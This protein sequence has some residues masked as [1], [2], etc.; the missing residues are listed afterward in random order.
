MRKMKNA[1]ATTLAFALICGSLPT[2][3]IVAAATPTISVKTKYLKVGQSSKLSIKNKA[4]KATYTFTSSNTKIATVNKTTGT[5]K[6]IKVG[7]CTVKLTAK[8]GSKTYTSTVKVLV[9]EH[10]SSIRISN[11]TDNMTMDIGSNVFEC[12]SLMKTKTGGRCTDSAFY[13]IIEETNT[14]GASVDDFGQISVEKPGSFQIVAVASDSL[15]TFH[16]K[17]YRAKSIPITVNIPV[18]LKAS[19][20]SVNQIKLSSNLPLNTYTKDDYMIWNNATGQYQKITNLEIDPKDNRTVTLTLANTFNR[21]TTFHINLSKADLS[22]SFTANYG[23]IHKIV[24]ND[25]AVAPNVATPLDYHIYDENGIDIT[26]LYPHT[27][28]GLEFSF[29]PTTTRLDEYGRI[30]LPNKNSYAFYSVKY[31][32]LDS[33]NRRQVLESNTASVTANASNIKSLKEF[34]IDTSSNI[35]WEKPSHALASG[36]TGRRLYCLFNNSTKGTIDTSKTSVNNLTFVSSDTTICAID[37]TTGLLYP[38]KQGTAQITVSD[39]IFTET[40]LISVGAPRT[41]ERLHASKTQLSLSNTSGLSNSESVRFELQDQYG[42]T[43]KLNSSGLNPFIRLLSGSDNMVS[44]NGRFVTRTSTYIPTTAT[45]NGYFDLTFYGKNAGT[46][47]IEVSYAGKTEIITI[48]I[49]QPGA[50]TTYKPELSE[51]TLDPNIQGKN[52]TT[53]TV[54]AVDQN[55]IKINTLNEGYYNITASDGTV[56]LPNQ[57]ISSVQTVI[58]STKLKLKDGNYNLTVTAGPVQ[59]TITF[60][61]KAS[62]AAVNLVAKENP[63]TTVKAN[64]DVATR[65]LDCFNLYLNGNPNT[66]PASSFVTGSSPLLSNVKISYTS[67]DT[68]YFESATDLSIGAKDFSKT[69]NGFTGTLRV[70]K[71]SFMFGGQLFNF[72]PDQD[73]TIRIQN[74]H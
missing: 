24:A 59:Q 22:A 50:V 44:V 11:M 71:V 53:L 26:L 12:Q 31:T 10:A 42:D 30:T 66:I 62:D 67:Y 3:P 5:V 43:F 7:D 20:Q 23:T 47:T 35:D 9:K 48:D 40:I 33:Y 2:V 56:I 14:A 41:M 68:K 28:A 36:E 8:V 69:Y 58:D 32:Y 57:M 49:R 13:Y 38:Y 61:V 21:N 39:G 73:I 70:T 25:Q 63:T 74:E 19:M 45:Y 18:S 54:Y 6:G 51:T 15:N 34:T 64:D 60:T 46:C 29:S 27:M 4:K 16:K 52:T 1:L 37:R 72:T 55:G 17:V 65:I